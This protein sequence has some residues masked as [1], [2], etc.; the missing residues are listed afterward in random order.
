MFVCGSF[1]K[2]QYYV[3]CFF[4]SQPVQMFMALMIFAVGSA[5]LSKEPTATARHHLRYPLQAD[6]A[7][8][9]RIRGLCFR[10]MNKLED[11]NFKDGAACQ[12]RSRSRCLC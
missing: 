7:R 2:S 5:T 11:A 8:A 12:C 6:A 4:Y 9:S 1:E 10:T 3:R